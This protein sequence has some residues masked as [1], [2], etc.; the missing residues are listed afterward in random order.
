MRIPS[1]LLA[2]KIKE[3][4]GIVP[5]KTT[6]EALYSLLVKNGYLIAS[7][8]EMTVM[9][10]LE[11]MEGTSE[12]F[13]LP[14]KAYNLL[15]NM[16]GGDTEIQCGNDFSITIIN[17]R[18]KS[19]FASM[20]PELYSF[21]LSSDPQYHEAE[22]DAGT[23]KTAISQCMFAVDESSAGGSVVM[24]AINLDAKDGVLNVCGMSRAQMAWNQINYSG[25]MKLLLPITAAKKLIS[26]NLR[27]NVKI[28]DNKKMVQFITDD[29]IFQARLTAGEYVDY[30]RLFNE[31][32]KWTTI[33]RQDMIQILG[34]INGIAQSEG[35]PLR[36]EFKGDE[37]NITYQ[38][39][40]SFYEETMF[41]VDPLTENDPIVIGFNPKLLLEMI[42]AYPGDEVRLNL[43]TPAMPML[44]S[45]DECGLRSMLLPVQI[46]A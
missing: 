28:R 46:R 40:T 20:D 1:A 17:G 10:K 44:V 2:K 42:K 23:L 22:I 35:A 15:M 34:R 31:L 14:P 39:Q 6:M 38:S 16:T 25:E 11:G 26:L 7:N 24:E 9:V 8:A 32:E 4:K 33:D 12:T 3:V 21:D 5:S 37:C 43:Q 29:C 41:L 13:L 45:A 36:M 27:G 18:S 19:R 30:S